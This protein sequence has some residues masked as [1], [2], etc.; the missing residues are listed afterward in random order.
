MG[1]ASLG[2]VVAQARDVAAWRH[3]GT[4]V[5]GLMEAKAQPGNVAFRIDDRPFRLLVQHGEADSVV[6]AGS[7]VLPATKPMPARS[8]N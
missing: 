5:L 1:V 4:Q 2:Y 8:I 3:F 7:G 6:A